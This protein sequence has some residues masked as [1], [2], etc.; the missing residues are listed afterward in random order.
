VIINIDNHIHS[1]FS[2]CCR[3]NYGLEQIYMVQKENNMRYA[4]VTDHIHETGETAGL[5]EH[6]SWLRKTAAGQK[7]DIPVFVAAE[8]TIINSDGDIPEIVSSADCQPDYLI[9]GC[10]YIPGKSGLNMGSIREAVRQLRKFSESDLQNLYNFHRNMIAGAVRRKKFDIFA[11]PFDFFYRCGIF[12]QRLLDGFR[13]FC[14]LCR[15]NNIAVELNNASA[16]RCLVDFADS[17]VF[18]SNCVRSVDFFMRMLEIVKS[19]NVKLSPASDAHSL[20]RIGYL[21]Y[22]EKAFNLAGFSSE[23]LFSLL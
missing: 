7:M 8:M 22:A 9:G 2:G 15:E 23:D 14:C 13:E 3:E 6:F 4:C 21:E 18:N 12:D 5:K 10:H 19:E 11:H 1:R 17:A 16:E 20:A